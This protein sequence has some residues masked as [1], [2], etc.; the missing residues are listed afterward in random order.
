[1]KIDERNEF[2]NFNKFDEFMKL[3]EQN[4]HRITKKNITE[5][6]IFINFCVQI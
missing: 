5:Q 3:S 1:M 6:K 2:K 4:E